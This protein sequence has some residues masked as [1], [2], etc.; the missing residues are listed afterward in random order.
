ML[1]FQIAG[2]AKGET[3]TKGKEPAFSD[4]RNAVE[5]ALSGIK[6]KNL[7]AKGT[8]EKKPEWSEGSFVVKIR[9]FSGD[10]DQLFGSLARLLQDEAER[11][12][13]TVTGESL[14]LEGSTLSMGFSYR[15]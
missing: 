9:N 1:V 5:N 10:R 3:G 15:K 12:G 11:I 8:L 4:I 2:E 14:Q 6:L 13:Y 7:E